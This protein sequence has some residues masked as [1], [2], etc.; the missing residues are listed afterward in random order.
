MTKSYS[1]IFDHDQGWSR[2]RDQGWSNW[3]KNPTFVN[4]RETTVFAS[5]FIRWKLEQKMSIT[6]KL[7]FHWNFSFDWMGIFIWIL[8]FYFLI[9]YLSKWHR[10]P[11]CHQGFTDRN[12]L[13]QNQL[14][15]TRNEPE[16]KD[17]CSDH[18][19]HIPDCHQSRPFLSLGMSALPRFKVN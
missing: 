15:R 2:D 14:V 7:N 18:F 19:G 3:W 1:C 12:R 16:Q 9:V 13:I 11:Y 8:T 6:P 17:K 5:K 4:L 10:N